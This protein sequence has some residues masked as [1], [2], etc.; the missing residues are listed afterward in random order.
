M[1]N[2]FSYPGALAEML[3]IPGSNSLQY[4]PLFVV[5]TV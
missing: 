5:F 4:S 3:Y 1:L 2:D